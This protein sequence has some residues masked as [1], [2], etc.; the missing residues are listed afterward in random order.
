MLGDKPFHLVNGIL[1]PVVMPPREFIDIALQVL[2]RHLVV[3]TDEASLQQ[4]PEAFNSVRMRLVAH[5]LTHGVVHCFVRPVN[6]LVGA[7]LV[8]VERRTV[9]EEIS[10]NYLKNI[11]NKSPKCTPAGSIQSVI[12]Q[13][14]SLY[15]GRPAIEHWTEQKLLSVGVGT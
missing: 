10:Q 6:P 14:Y 11:S 12:W 4:C 9:C 13:S 15:P 8:R 1:G 2:G 7:G 5:I 3:D